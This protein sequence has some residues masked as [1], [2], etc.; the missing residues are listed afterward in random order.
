MDS[1]DALTTIGSLV[2]AWCDRRALGP[3]RL[4]LRGYPLDNALTDG[5][6]ELLQSLYDVRA[7]CRTLPEAERGQL[8]ACIVAVEQAVHRD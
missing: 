6:M 2:D 5:W 7:S 3:L 4:I 8:E 1:Q